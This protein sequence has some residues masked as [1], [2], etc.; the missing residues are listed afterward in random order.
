MSVEDI[1]G[2][3]IYEMTWWGYDEETIRKN[4]EERMKKLK[5]K[6][7]EKEEGD[8]GAVTEINSKTQCKNFIKSFIPTIIPAIAGKCGDAEFEHT[9][10]EVNCVENGA[11]CEPIDLKVFNLPLTSIAF[12]YIYIDGACMFGISTE[13][14]GKTAE[15]VYGWFAPSL[16][17]LKDILESEKCQNEIIDMLAKQIDEKVN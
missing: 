12:Y 10:R 5:E 16:K 14:E 1:L 6:N 11:Y 7:E 4:Y 13:I 3:C 9:L 17:E 15:I 8:D 2:N